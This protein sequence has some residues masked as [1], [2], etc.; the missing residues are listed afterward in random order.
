MDYFRSNFRKTLKAKGVRQEKGFSGL[1]T[2]ANTVTKTRIA[3]MM[4]LEI[5]YKKM[6]DIDIFKF[7]N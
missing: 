6:A 1:T 3:M 4:A 2:N 7:N 5:N